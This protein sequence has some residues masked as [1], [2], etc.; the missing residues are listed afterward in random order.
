MDKFSALFSV[1]LIPIT[2]II[3]EE[4]L[5]IMLLRKE[6]VVFY[7]YSEIIH[8]LTL[9]SLKALKVTPLF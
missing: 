2:E 6:I 8:L 7:L 9:T 5:H 4:R 3:K 1:Q